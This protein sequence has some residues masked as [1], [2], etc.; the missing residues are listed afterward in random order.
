MMKFL[1]MGMG[2][3]YFDSGIVDRT[4]I[5][6]DGRIVLYPKS[7]LFVLIVIATMFLIIYLAVKLESIW[8]NRHSRK[9]DRELQE[10]FNQKMDRL[11]S[12]NKT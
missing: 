1:M 5:H 9:L 3:V 2:G 8:F 6:D 10:E 4:G 12:E 11:E 7:L